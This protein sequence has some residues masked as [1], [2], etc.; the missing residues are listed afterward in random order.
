MFPGFASRIEREMKKLYIESLSIS[1]KENRIRI[2]INIIDDQRRK[3][4]SFIGAFVFSDIY[5][6]KEYDNYWISKGDWDEYGEKII[7][8]K[9][10]NIFP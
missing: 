1:E 8:K 9:C 10:A 7:L 2:P 5:V 4:L 3:N 6:K